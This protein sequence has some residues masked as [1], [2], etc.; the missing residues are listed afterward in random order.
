MPKTLEYRHPTA[1][2]TAALMGGVDSLGKAARSSPKILTV[3]PIPI[4]KVTIPSPQPQRVNGSSTLKRSVVS[5]TAA[6]LILADW[7]RSKTRTNSAIITS[8]PKR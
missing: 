4:I 2:N 3:L 7:A 5:A 1:A 6:L 8:T